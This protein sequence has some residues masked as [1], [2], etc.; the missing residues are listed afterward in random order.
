LTG[1][2][3]DRVAER[4]ERE[5]DWP[6]ATM[7][8]V[9]LWMRE[10]GSDAEERLRELLKR[11]DLPRTTILMAMLHRGDLTAV[12]ELLN[13]TGEPTDDLL[14]LLDKHR[15]WFVLSRFLPRDRAGVPDPPPFWLWADRDLQRFQLDVLRNWWLLYGERLTADAPPD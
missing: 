1:L 5:V 3:S 6:T 4:I 9:G 7:M 11:S 8:R 2:M 15:W 10:D 12:D 13:P 14:T